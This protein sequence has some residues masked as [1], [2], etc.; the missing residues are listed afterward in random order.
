MMRWYGEVARCGTAWQPSLHRS[1]SSIGEVFESF[2]SG[3]ARQMAFYVFML[4]GDSL[5]G[6]FIAQPRKPDTGVRAA[7]WQI[8]SSG[9]KN[10]R[11][12]FGQTR[13]FGGAEVVDTGGTRASPAAGERARDG[14]GPVRARD[15]RTDTHR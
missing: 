10:R 9:S 14:I 8:P 7:C 6:N 2:L 12:F 5:V 4:W 1:N 11:H 13:Q 3:K 15:R